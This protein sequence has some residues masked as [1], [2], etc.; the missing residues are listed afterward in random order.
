[1]WGEIAAIAGTS[2]FSGI[3]G[4]KA[5]KSEERAAG[6]AADLQWKMYQ[7]GR[8]DLAPWREAGIYGLNALTGEMEYGMSM[9]RREDFMTKPSMTYDFSDFSAGPQ[10]IPGTPTFDEAAYNDAMDKYYA[11]G[12]RTGGLLEGPGEFTEDPGYQFRLSQGVNALDRSAASRGSVGGGAHKKAL[13]EYGQGL[14]SQEYQNFLNRYYESLNPYFSLAGMGQVSAGQGASMGT[15]T[16]Q[17][18]GQ[19]YLAGGRAKAGGYANWANA[20]NS[21][22]E[23]YISM[24]GG[25]GGGGGSVNPTPELPWYGRD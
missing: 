22:M 17:L 4:D 8:E 20:L 14:G 25:F 24:G 2:I 12:E 7:Q 10:G 1:M 15:Q 5:A 18:M 9:P 21:G 3:M 6:K 16:G 13:L 19:N 11:S 23:N